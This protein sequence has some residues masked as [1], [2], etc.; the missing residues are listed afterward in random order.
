MNTL[1]KRILSRKESPKDPLNPR[2]ER[3]EVGGA[4]PFKAVISLAQHDGQGHL[5]SKGNVQEWAGKLVDMSAKGVSIQLHP[6][7]VAVRGEPCVVIIA[8]DTY[9]LKISGTVAHFRIYPQH[10]VCGV[11][12]SFSDLDVEVAYHQIL[13]SVII[14]A[15]LTAVDPAKLVQDIDELTKRQYVGREGSSLTL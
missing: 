11:K 9:R 14:G 12:F 4:F 6:A 13:K 2:D 10:A 8:L 5:L 1:F 15:S 3:Y 7:S